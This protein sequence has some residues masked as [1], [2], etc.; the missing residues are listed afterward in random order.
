MKKNNILIAVALILGIFSSCEKEKPDP[1]IIDGV[2]SK[3]IS[4]KEGNHYESITLDIKSPS[5]STTGVSFKK[6]VMLEGLQTG[7]NSNGAL[8]PEKDP[9]TGQT[10]TNPETGTPMLSVGCYKDMAV[11]CDKLGAL[12]SVKTALGVSSLTDLITT[13]TSNGDAD[14]DGFEDESVKNALI[15]AGYDPTEFT[16]STMYDPK[17]GFLGNT[18]NDTIPANGVMTIDGLI[19]GSSNKNLTYCLLTNGTKIDTIY[20]IG[21]GGKKL[22]P[23]MS[24]I[25]FAQTI[26]PAKGVQGS[27][28]K[29]WHIPSDGEWKILEMALGM[30][31]VDVN[32]EDIENDRGEKEDLA[33]KLAYKLNLNYSGY[34][35]ENGTFAQLGEVDAFWTSTAGVDKDGREYVWIRY[36]DTMTHKGIIRKKQYEK[37]GFSVRCFHD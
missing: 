12:Y 37:S 31:A 28:P 21:A 23:D 14:G 16:I 9:T 3:A 8:K 34:W 2:K 29:D 10:V 36:I 27:C 4:D 20:T 13:T 25:N 35:S 18:V 17:T 26:K 22:V 30:S 1:I 7:S 33:T 6:D 11:N 5:T 32:K 19:T 24:K 15:A